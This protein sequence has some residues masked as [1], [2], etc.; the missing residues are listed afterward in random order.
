MTTWSVNSMY[1]IKLTL[2]VYQL[3]PLVHNN[4]Y[5]IEEGITVLEKDS[6]KKD[7]VLQIKTYKSLFKTYHEM[8]YYG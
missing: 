8:T 4:C 5:G 2:P 1:K 7:L 3:E 6:L